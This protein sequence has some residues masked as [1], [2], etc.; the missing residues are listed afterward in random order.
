VSTPKARKTK[1][2]KVKVEE[3][4]TGEVGDGLDGQ[5]S[6]APTLLQEQTDGDVELEREINFF[7][8]ASFGT[9]MFHVE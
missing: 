8:D 9:E 4:E 2:S 1:T 3:T 5:D 6:T 7:E